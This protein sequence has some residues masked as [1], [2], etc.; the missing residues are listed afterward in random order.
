MHGPKAHQ[1]ELLRV[2]RHDTGEVLCAGYVG[3]D[4]AEAR[5]VKSGELLPLSAGEELGE[6]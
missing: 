6:G 3:G 2:G 4:R 5:E 1:G